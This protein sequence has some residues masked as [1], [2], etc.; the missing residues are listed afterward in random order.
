MTFV[1]RPMLASPHAER[2]EP[3]TEIQFTTFMSGMTDSMTSLL[4]GRLNA[5]RRSPNHT[6]LLEQQAQ[7]LHPL[8]IHA[9]VTVAEA[10]R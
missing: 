2:A 8:S 7:I 3:L 1:K 5:L 10:R 9:E 6:L 4:R